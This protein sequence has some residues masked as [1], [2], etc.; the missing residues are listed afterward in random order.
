MENIENISII[1][2]FF[3]VKIKFFFFFFKPR[4]FD[5][6]VSQRMKKSSAKIDFWQLFSA[7][8]PVEKT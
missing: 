7:A 2:I 5:F 3:C 4:V 6:F 8:P 1:Y